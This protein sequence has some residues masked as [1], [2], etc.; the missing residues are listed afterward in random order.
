MFFPEPL[1]LLRRYAVTLN[2]LIEQAPE[3]DSHDDLYPECD[4]VS[5]AIQ[6]CP[7]ASD[8]NEREH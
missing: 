6:P 1:Y 7:A 3:T 8:I 5:A 4:P 2:Q